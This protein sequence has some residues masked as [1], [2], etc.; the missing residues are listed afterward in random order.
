MADRAARSGTQAFSR[1]KGTQD[2]LPADMPQRHLLEET[3]EAVMSRYGYREI[4]TPVFESTE[5]FQRSVGMATDIVNKE[6]YS[7]EDQGGKSLTLRPELTAPVVRA[8]LQGNLGK[9]NP[10]TRLYYLGD[11]FRQERPQKGRHRQ[12]GQFGAEAL[13]SPHPEQDVEIIALAWDICQEVAPDGLALRINSLGDPETRTK[14]LAM[15]TDALADYGS[16]MGE[17]DRL[18]LKHNPLRLFDSKDP[19]T[20]QLLRDH[21]PLISENISDTDRKHF[22]AVQAGLTRLDIKYEIDEKLVRGLDYYTGTV[23]EITSE[24]LGAQDAVCGGGRYDGL[25]AELGGHDTPAVGFAAGIERL[26]LASGEAFKSA[27]LQP[28][29][30]VYLAVIG[31][32]PMEKAPSMAAALRGKGISVM[33]ET[34]RRSLKAQLREANR[35]GARYTLILGEDELAKG[36]CSLKS[37]ATGDQEEVDISELTEVVAGRLEL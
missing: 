33:L 23:F 34:L 17:T 10:L 21:A 1:S 5:L 27:A 15:L 35:S 16:S 31:D 7:F 8:Y 14:Y 18:R 36:V 12:F 19:Y 25:V 11:L 4:R 32:G 2:I 24:A 9:E 28:R 29:P 6:M 20:Q 22:D 3:V 30:D 26:L 37:M 13:G